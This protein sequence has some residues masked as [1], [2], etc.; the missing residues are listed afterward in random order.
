[1]G[2]CKVIRF[3]QLYRASKIRLE[4]TKALASP[5]IKEFNVIQYV[6]AGIEY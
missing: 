3:P 2:D 4:I 1:M 6:S 5:S